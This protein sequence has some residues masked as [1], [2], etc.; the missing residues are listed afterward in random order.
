MTLDAVLLCALAAGPPAPVAAENL[1]PPTSQAYLRWDGVKAHAGA[2]KKSAFGKMFAGELGRSLLAIKA[3]AETAI[4]AA[5]VG[6]KMLGGAKMAE[7]RRQAD[8]IDSLLALPTVLA[9]HGFAFAAEGGVASSPGDLIGRIGKLVSG[10]AGPADFTPHVQLTFIIPDAG[11]RPEVTK[12]IKA[13]SAFKGLVKP[14]RVRGRELHILRDGRS[15]MSW[16]WWPEGRHLAVVATAGDPVPAATRVIDAGPGIANNRLYRSLSAKRGFEVTTRGYIDVRSLSG[17]VRL[18]RMVA[19][20]AAS[21][22]EEL[23][24]TDIEALRIWEGLDGEDSRATWEVA[25]AA[26]PRGVGRLLVNKPLDLKALPP[27]PEDAYRWTAGRLDLSAAFDILLTYAAVFDPELS[28]SGL[29]KAKDRAR[30]MLDDALGVK[31]DDIFSSLGDALLAHASAGDGV[32]FL[33]QV[34]AVSVKDEKKLAR[35]LD[36][37]VKRL[38]STSGV[39]FHK[40]AFGGATIREFSG[41]RRSPF[42]VAYTIHDGWLA[43]S[44][45]TQPIKGFVSRKAGKLPAWKPDARTAKALAAI[46]ADAGLVQVIDPRPGVNVMLSLAPFIA[47]V[48]RLG[49]FRDDTEEPIFQAS[50]MPHPGSVTKHLFP[51]VSWSSFDG[52]TWRVESRESVWL[53]LQEAGMEWMLFFTRG[54]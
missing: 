18:L 35:S 24:L 45:N 40:H 34:I 43:F 37:A 26:K 6:D 31:S 20:G 47:N 19:P 25:F 14:H 21:A 9:D 11:N 46:P 5:Q 50:D 44:L 16:A 13:L 38:A 10:K 41:G 29:S 51:N 2:Y 39:R 53:P 54:I 12:A 27:I 36:G 3:R 8:L 4:K 49:P 42:S 32:S 30:L 15:V 22:L 52:K 7:L 1:L 17:N 48:A 28:T 33:G 23:G